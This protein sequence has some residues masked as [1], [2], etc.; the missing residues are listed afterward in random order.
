MENSL[1]IL[2]IDTHQNASPENL[3]DLLCDSQS[4]TEGEEEEKP[5][6]KRASFGFFRRFHNNLRAT[7]TQRNSNIFKRES[8][9]SKK[10]AKKDKENKENVIEE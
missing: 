6:K 9:K 10:K 4:N 1:K 2:I 7:L 5:S 3:D 8:R